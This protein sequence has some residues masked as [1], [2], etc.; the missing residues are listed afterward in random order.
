MS[1]DLRPF[2]VKWNGIGADDVAALDS[3][4]D[5]AAD[6][7]PVQSVLA[8]RP[9]LLSQILRGG[10]GRWVIPQPRLGAELVPDFLL[11]EGCSIGLMWVAVE[12]E[13]PTARLFTKQ[14]DPTATLVHAIRQVHDWRA[15]LTQNGDYASRPKEKS[16]LGFV[17]IDG[18]IPGLILLGRRESQ[19]PATRDRR[20]QMMKDSRIAIHSYDWLLETCRGSVRTVAPEQ[21]TSNGPVQSGVDVR[22]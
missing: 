1:P 13:S 4:L 5:S 11:A 15:W 16:G 12:L 6:E 10:H 2:S 8:T 14:G 22:G 20:R 7:R 17:D 9:V 18:S 3:T 19:D 21:S